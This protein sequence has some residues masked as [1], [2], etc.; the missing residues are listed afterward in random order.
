MDPD[1]PDALAVRAS[2]LRPYEAELTVADGYLRIEVPRGALSGSVTV[3][4]GGSSL[5]PPPPNRH[6]RRRSSKIP[7]GCH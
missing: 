7:P 3:L 1:D 5:S 4:L 6:Q 2:T